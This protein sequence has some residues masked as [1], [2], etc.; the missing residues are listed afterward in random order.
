MRL[1]RKAYSHARSLIEAGKVDQSSKWSFT[2]EDE[3]KLLGD[4]PDWERYGKW[5]LGVDPEADAETKAHYKYPFGKGGKLY[6]SALRAIRSRSAQ[7]GH[8]DIFE[9]SGKLLEMLDAEKEKNR[10]GSLEFNAY[11]PGR[12]VMVLPLG[13]VRGR[14]GRYWILERDDAERIVEQIKAN[15]VDIVLDFDHR[16]YD[17]PSDGRAAGWF[18]ADSFEVQ[19]DGIYALLELTE[20]GKQAVESREYRYLSPAFWSQGT[21]ILELESVGLTNIPNIPAIPALNKKEGTMNDDLKREINALKERNETLE[22]ELNAVKTE[23]DQAL[24]EINKLKGE[25]EEFKKKELER[26]IN[27][28]VEKAIADGKLAP[29]QKET[30]IK[31]GLNSKELLEELINSS[32][33]DFRKL[34]VPQARDSQDDNNHGLDDATLQVCRMLGLKPEDVAKHAAS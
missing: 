29:A 31:L 22:R 2:T 25:L 13:E 21:R 5:F 19:E 7:H 1:N 15:G 17:Y 28:L 16:T 10:C 11:E 33:Y 18:L 27:E 14:D 23:R 8:E 30:A 34:S 26:E 12:P 4:P 20:A 9:A 32:P 24:L 3:N 6:R